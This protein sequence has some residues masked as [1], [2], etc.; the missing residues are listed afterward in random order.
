MLVWDHENLGEGGWERRTSDEID[1]VVGGREIY[2]KRLRKTR[3]L[4]RSTLQGYR[5][6]S[7]HWNGGD[8]R[9]KAV[10]SSATNRGI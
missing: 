1:R 9:M 8:K 6:P 4:W 10:V 2:I 3:M 5:A 7:I